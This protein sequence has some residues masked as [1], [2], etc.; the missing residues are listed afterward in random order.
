MSDNYPLT[1][2]YTAFIHSDFYDLLTFSNTITGNTYTAEIR[3]GDRTKIATITCT[4]E[5]ANDLKLYIA[6][7]T[8]ATLTEGLY[9]WDLKE[10]TTGI[11]GGQIII[12]GTF[13]INKAQT[14]T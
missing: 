13:E 12:A 14:E 9:N 3:D 8:M 5:S 11:A 4:I 10:V 1:L 6:K 7:T 2:N